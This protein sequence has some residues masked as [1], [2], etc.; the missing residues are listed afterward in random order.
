MQYSHQR[1]YMC[2]CVHNRAVI[3]VHAEYKYGTAWKSAGGR[4]NIVAV[5]AYAYAFFLLTS[6]R[7]GGNGFKNGFHT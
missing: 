7:D 3:P 5:R 6:G 1:V 4:S 2:T